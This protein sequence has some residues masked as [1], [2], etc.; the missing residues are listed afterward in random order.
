MSITSLNRTDFR[1]SWHFNLRLDVPLSWSIGTS[2]KRAIYLVSPDAVGSRSLLWQRFNRYETVLGCLVCGA[3]VVLLWPIFGWYLNTT[4]LFSCQHLAYVLDR[5]HWLLHL[6]V[7]LNFIFVQNRKG[8]RKRAFLLLDLSLL[9][10]CPNISIEWLF[11][12]SF[13]VARVLK[14]GPSFL[15]KKEK[16]LKIYSFLRRCFLFFDLGWTIW[17]FLQLF[18]HHFLIIFNIFILLF[19]LFCFL[20]FIYSMIRNNRIL[21]LLLLCIKCLLFHSSLRTCGVEVFV[22]S[23]RHAVL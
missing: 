7:V 3:V 15:L 16:W 13:E 4:S 6:M 18:I 10:D 14:L 12:E 8:V 23:A 9:T 19:Y 5:V 22:V 17:F 20:L 1:L 11:L 2:C 21:N